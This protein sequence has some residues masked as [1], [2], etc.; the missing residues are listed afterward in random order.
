[1]LFFK[2]ISTRTDKISSVIQRALAPH[3]IQYEEEYGLITLSEVHVLPDLSEARIFVHSMRS[4][5]RLIQTLNAH[6]GV[7]KK[8]ISQNLT[9]KRTP[10]LIFMIDTGSIASQHIDE[11]L[12]TDTK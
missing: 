9:Q 11:L 3:M 2:I 5:K 12:R 8:N 10:K 4:M 7:L 1:M 6:A